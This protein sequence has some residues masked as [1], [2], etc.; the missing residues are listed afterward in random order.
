MTQEQA[1]TERAAFHALRDHKLEPL[2]TEGPITAYY[3]RGP[4]GGR[5]MST[6]IMFTPEGIVLQGDLTPGRNG[7][8]SSPW[9]G[10]GWFSGQLSGSYLCEKFLETKWVRELAVEQLSDPVASFY[11]EADDA[12]VEKLKEIAKVLSGGDYGPEWLHEELSNLDGCYVDDGIPGLGY[13]PHEA[14]WLVAIQATFARLYH[15]QY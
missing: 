15:A 3:L 8:V 4:D 2:I 6:L 12:D 5:M 11:C 1:K 14:A 7:N 13:D 9:Y 10:V